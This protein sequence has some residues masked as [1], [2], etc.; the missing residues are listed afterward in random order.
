MFKVP[1]DGG[2][3]V[4]LLDSPSYNPLWSP[5]DRFIIYSEPLKGGTFLVK[6]ITPDKVPVPMPDIR[7]PYAM[8][9]PYRFASGGK[10]LI[11]FKDGNARSRNFFWLDLETGLGRQLTALKPGFLIQSFDVRPDGKQI[12]STGYR[13]NSDIVMMD[14]TR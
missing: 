1:L 11:F 6:A 8:A 13:E 5:D 10:A 3:A 4:R 14:L 12:V 9:T 2:P 7:V